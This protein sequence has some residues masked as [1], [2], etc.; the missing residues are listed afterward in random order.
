MYNRSA[1]VPKDKG[2]KCQFIQSTFNAGSSAQYHSG[3]E[4]DPVRERRSESGID[5]SKTDYRVAFL[6]EDT[7]EVYEGGWCPELRQRHGRGICAYADG[8]LYEGSWI[9]GK[10][11]GKGSLM[12]GNRQLI[13]LGEW[14]DGYIHG[15]YLISNLQT[16][17][18][19]S[20]IF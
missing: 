16:P 12:T 13:Y 9:Y 17:L 20:M 8:T 5:D 19:C 2:V 15:K 18:S 3:R 11:Q 4:Q 7:G 1:S 6:D 10:E 14:V